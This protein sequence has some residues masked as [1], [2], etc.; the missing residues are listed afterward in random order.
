MLLEQIL[1]LLAP[2]ELVN[3][4]AQSESANQ[5]DVLP[6]L[7]ALQTSVLALNE[8]VQRFD[9]TPR[10]PVVIQPTA[11]MPCARAISTKTFSNG[12]L[13]K[14]LPTGAFAFEMQYLLIPP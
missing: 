14:I 1:S 7:Y 4:R 6:T 10:N 8:P 3:M 11:L 5:V 2:I 13:T 9:S 12:T